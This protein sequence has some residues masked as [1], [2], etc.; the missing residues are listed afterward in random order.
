MLSLRGRI[1][2]VMFF[3]MWL[4]ALLLGRRWGLCSLMIDQVEFLV[5]FKIPPY[6]IAILLTG[7]VM[8]V[9]FHRGQVFWISYSKKLHCFVWNFMNPDVNLPNWQYLFSYFP[10]LLW[11]NI[12]ASALGVSS[13]P[14]PIGFFGFR[15][16]IIWDRFIGLPFGLVLITRDHVVISQFFVWFRLMPMAIE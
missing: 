14:P 12:V 6:T 11:P 4:V 7:H 5:I 10:L 8:G 2:N 13:L 16:I 1:K 9:L 3:F 15:F